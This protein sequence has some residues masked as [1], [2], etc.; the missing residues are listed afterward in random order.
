MQDLSIMDRIRRFFRARQ[1]YEPISGYRDDPASS[2]DGAED[3]FKFREKPFSKVEYWIFL[4]MGIAMLWAWN[5]F[6]AAA[7]YFQH[8]FSS[9]EWILAHFQSAEISVSTITN[10]GSML[11]LTKLQ[12]NASYPYRITASLCINIICFTLLALS[13]LVTTSAVLYFAFL[14]LMVFSASLA[15]GLIQNGVFAYVSGYGRSEYTQAIMTG[16][17]VAGVLPCIAQIASVLAIPKKSQQSSPDQ[18]PSQ[19]PKSALAYFLTATI[20][21]VISL[22]AF[23][24]LLRRS[25]SGSITHTLPSSPKASAAN[26]SSEGEALTNPSTE[27]DSG[28]Q[29]S[30]ERKAV[31][32]TH[33][34]RKIPFL[35]TA[36][37]LCFAVTMF[38]P[39]FTASIRSVHDASIPPA[40]FI[41][42]AFLVWNS[43]D[44]LGRLFTLWPAVSLTNHPFALFCLSVARLIFI[45]LYLL[46][47]VGGNGARVQSD[48]F[49]LGFVQLLFG[50]SNGYIG[51]SCMMAAGEWVDPEERE[52]A[53][54]FMG[55]CLVAGLTVGSLLSFSVTVV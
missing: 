13:T 14:M 38:F 24:Y 44:L 41:P 28:H 11:A 32:L 42:I 23:I 35:S 18:A 8:R 31:S 25:R 52:A 43:G 10:L 1:S 47:N 16:Q 34:L 37:L 27:S 50:I 26:I 6:L 7:P 9:D 12:E 29:P 20:F 49:Y 15:T 40:L 53:G 19:S 45:P 21:S 17:A 30:P 39:V 22:L 48:F 4:L 36:L 5:M 55:L 33:L 3:A 54:G 2:E 51:S 46:C